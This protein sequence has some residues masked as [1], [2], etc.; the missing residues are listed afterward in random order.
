MIHLEKMNLTGISID[1]EGAKAIETILE[2]IQEI[3]IAA[4]LNSNA[5]KELASIFST[6]RIHIDSLLKITD[7]SS[8]LPKPTVEEPDSDEPDGDVENSDDD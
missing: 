1:K 7:G 8:S 4:Q 6:S 3:A 2:T 5:L